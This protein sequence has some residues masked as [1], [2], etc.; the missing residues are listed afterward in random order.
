[1]T[2]QSSLKSDSAL[3]VIDMISGFDFKDAER[4]FPQAVEVARNVASLVKR[5][6]AAGVPIIYLNDNFGR[7]NVDFATFLS[8]LKAK[9]N[10]GRQILEILDLS[11]DDLFVLKPQRSGFYGTSLGVLL[12]SLGVSRIVLTGVTTDI[13]VLFTA[14]DA[15]MRGYHV[16]IP[17][18]CCAAVNPSDHVAALRFLERVAEADTAH[19]SAC[20]FRPAAEVA[21]SIAA[22]AGS[23]ISLTGDVSLDGI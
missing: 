10:R 4:L 3:L 21:P 15:F 9:S 11:A 12:L 5:A 22:S 6:K 1:M 8:D 20:R 19:S 2:T 17:A 18:D 13:C 7:W 14:H 16:E 23:I